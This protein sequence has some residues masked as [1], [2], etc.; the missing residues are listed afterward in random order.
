MMFWLLA[1]LL[2]LL[3]LG[4][5]LLP[6]WRAKEEDRP[7]GRRWLSLLLILLL[8]LTTLVF[9]RE[10]GAPAILD[11]QPA[12]QGKSHDAE[13]MLAALESRLKT[14]PDDAEGW[15]VLGRAYLTLQHV[16]DA[17]TAL[18]RAVKLAPKEAR[19]LSHY[20]E[21]AAIADQGDLQKRARALVETALELDPQEE[22]A[23]ELAGLA[24]Y[25]REAWAQAAF[26]W[27]HL[28]KRLPPGS[29]F[30]QDIE[31]ALKKARGMAEHAS[32]LG[33]KATLEP[34]PKR[35]MP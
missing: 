7:S 8:P 32:G 28:L 23:L 9:Y 5:L 12:L 16:A 2:V 11:V 22:K 13:A 34:S 14:K 27:R 33:E 25:Q 18:V 20:A 10:L 17:E 4:L 26:Y 15:Y 21:V 35:A 31:A 19:Y 3:A 30:Y 29:E 1:V 24:A 6:L